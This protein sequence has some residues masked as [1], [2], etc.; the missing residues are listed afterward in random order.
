MSSRW[1]CNQVEGKD[2]SGQ[3][4]Q[5]ALL[6]CKPSNSLNATQFQTC[7]CPTIASFML[8][9]FL[10]SWQPHPAIPPQL[11][12][13][14]RP[15]RKRL[16]W[17][18]GRP[19]HHPYPL[20]TSVYTMLLDLDTQLLFLANEGHGEKQHLFDCKTY[21]RSPSNA[22]GVFVLQLHNLSRPVG[23]HSTYT[24]AWGFEYH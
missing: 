23:T 4:F 13:K 15:G 6:T 3:R 17:A 10:Y 11:R 14:L 7:Q 21:Q 22:T 2:H 1:R 20:N 9:P 19:F 12:S 24:V 5:V 16:A 18:L 8:K